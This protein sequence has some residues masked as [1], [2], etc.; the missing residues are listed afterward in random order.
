MKSVQNDRKLLDEIIMLRQQLEEANDTINAIKTG[1]IDAIVVEDDNGHQLY[2]LKTA[3]HAYRV[4]IEKMKE[5]AVTLNTS[6]IIVYSNSQFAAMV[7]I[8]LTKVIGLPIETFIPLHQRAYFGSLLEKGWESDSRGEIFLQDKSG[9]L[10]PYLLSLTSLDLAEGKELSI[11][12]TDLSIQ[13][14]TEYQLKEKNEQ[15]EIAQQSLATLNEELE[16]IVRE[17]T[18]D[19]LQS[20]EHFKFLADNIPIIVWTANAEGGVDYINNRWFDYTGLST[21]PIDSG[22]FTSVIHPDDRE[23]FLQ[24]WQKAK[25]S[26]EGFEWEYRL[27]EGASG[28]YRSHLIYAQPFVDEL[29][30]I[31]AWFGTSTDIEEQKKQLQKK[32][33]FIGIASH[34]L[35]TPLT[36]LKGYIQLIERDVILP[37]PTDQYIRKANAAIN[38]LH[39]LVNDL[40]DV[41]KIQA[42]KLQFTLRPLDI[43]ELVLHCVENSIHIYPEMAVQ[44]E[45]APGCMVNGNEERLE[46]VMMNLINNAMKYS[47][48]RMDLNVRVEKEGGEVMVSV[49]DHGI[50]LSIADQEKIFERFYRVEDKS[51]LTSGLG[52]GLYISAQIIKE[53]GGKMRV[54][55]RL[56]KGSVFSVM[57]PLI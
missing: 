52:M 9:R 46:Q 32:D 30:K 35:K 33:E 54:E 16:D 57:L 34:E 41:S 2:T 4:F 22:D 8:P 40:L 43:S 21:R 3:D 25:D 20:R 24:V 27:K 29:G 28:L 55:S 6:E 47:R 44:T 13:K 12:L 1:Q 11:I 51:F 17:R 42:G 49:E 53:H 5:G 14:E 26:N 7:D 39:H 50:G 38:K 18:K 15:L 36:S 48:G 23:G 37:V 31:M 45:I 19:L 10:L 56:K